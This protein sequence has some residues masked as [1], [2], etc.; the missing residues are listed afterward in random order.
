MG[1]RWI[2]CTYDGRVVRHL[3]Y[4]EH[5]FSPSVDVGPGAVEQLAKNRVERLC[6]QYTENTAG[7][8]VLLATRRRC[9][10]RRRRFHCQT[11]LT[12]FSEPIFSLR[13]YRVSASLSPPAR[14]S[15]LRRPRRLTVYCALSVPMNHRS[16]RS[17]LSCSVCPSEMDANSSGC[18]HQYAGNSVSD[19]GDRMTGRKSVSRSVGSGTEAIR[20]IGD[21]RPG[22]GMG[23]GL[24]GYGFLRRE[25]SDGLRSWPSAAPRWI[26]STPPLGA[27]DLRPHTPAQHRG[28][29]APSSGTTSYRAL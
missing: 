21:V 14:P 18:S 7:P 1:M 20:F 23:C 4:H 27:E 6:R 3:F 13:V 11:R 26:A 24:R 5:G 19:T 28:P 29:R 8:R 10:Y 9:R 15:R 22:I 16:T 12:F 17:T 2:R 25:H